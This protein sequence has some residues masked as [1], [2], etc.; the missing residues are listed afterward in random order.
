MD[1]LAWNRYLTTAAFKYPNLLKYIFKVEIRFN[2]NWIG[3][4]RSEGHKHR[5][6]WYLQ[7]ETDNLHQL[8]ESSS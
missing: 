3:K 4:L 7:V 8:S 6:T 5:V 1:T 2:L